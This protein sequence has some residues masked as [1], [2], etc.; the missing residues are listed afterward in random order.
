MS[1]DTE[2]DVA[3]NAIFSMGLIGAG[4][5]NARLAQ[6]FRQLASYHRDPNALFITR[7]AQGLT[8]LGK[9]TQTLNPF[10]TE[11]KILS[12]TTLASL[13]TVAIAFSDPNFILEH[14]Y[15]L[16]FLNSAARPRVLVTV[17]E[18]LNE[19]PVTVRVGK[20]VDVVGQAGKPKT[21]T[22]WVTQTTPVLLGYG[23]KAELEENSEYIA[24]SSFLDGIVIL[25]K[26]PDYVEP[27]KST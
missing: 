21:I 9:G 20:A 15:F 13:L 12:K 11:G 16:F 8:H 22:G 17:D 26:N 18:D 2:I 14:H 7:I 5:N 27:D 25:K 3:I 19:L 10:T 23:E 1:H 4:T 24:L 6:L